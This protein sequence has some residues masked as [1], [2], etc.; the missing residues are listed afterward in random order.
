ML[1]FRLRPAIDRIAGRLGYVPAAQLVSATD[2]LETLRTDAAALLKAHKE[3]HAAATAAV[4]ALLYNQDNRA[5]IDH[6]NRSLGVVDAQ[7]I[8]LEDRRT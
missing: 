8:K 1:R 5:K 7:I 6:M 3:Y 2:A 4:A